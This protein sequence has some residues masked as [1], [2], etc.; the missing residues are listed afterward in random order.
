MTSQYIIVI[1]LQLQFNNYQ[2]NT[3]QLSYIYTSLLIYSY[4]YSQ[5]QQEEKFHYYLIERFQL[6]IGFK[7]MWSISMIQLNMLN[8]LSHFSYH[9]QLNLVIYFLA[10]CGMESL[11]IKIVQ[12]FLKQE[13]HEDICIMSTGFMFTKDKARRNH[14]QMNLEI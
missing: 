14:Y 9:Y 7:G 2:A 13:K 8:V 6:N 11:K 5:I 1:F 3:T 10:F 4:F 12:I